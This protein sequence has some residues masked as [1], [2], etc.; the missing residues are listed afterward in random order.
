MFFRVAQ[1]PLTSTND[2]DHD[3]IPDGW[4]LQLG[5]NPLLASDATQIVPGDGR[6]WLDLP[7]V[8]LAPDGVPKGCEVQEPDLHRDLSLCALVV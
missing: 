4:E 2:E 5:R 3:G 8:L 1:F 7:K 6:T